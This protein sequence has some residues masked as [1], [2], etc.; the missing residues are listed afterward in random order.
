MIRTACKESLCLCKVA[1]YVIMSAKGSHC[2]YSIQTTKEQLSNSDVIGYGLQNGHV[3]VVPDWRMF[4]WLWYWTAEWSLG[5]GIGLQ[6]GHV[7]VV[8]DCRMVTW[9]WYR[10]AEWSR[11]CGIGL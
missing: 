6:N 8:S 1:P 3:A 11:G 2:N 10:N 5:C 7:A 4:T 9:L